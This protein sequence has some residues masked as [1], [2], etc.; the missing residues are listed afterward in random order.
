MAAN[1]SSQVIPNQETLIGDL[2]DIDMSSG[3]TTSMP[4]AQPIPQSSSM[5]LLGEGLDSLLGGPSVAA[6]PAGTAAAAAP[7]AGAPAAQEGGNALADLLGG[8]G[9]SGGANMTGGATVLPKEVWLPAARGKGLEVTGTFLRRNCQVFM[10]LTVTNRA[11][12]PMSDFAVQFNKN[13][14]GLTIAAPLQIPPLNAGQ[15]HSTTLLLGVGG[16]VA[17]M[18]PLMNLQ[19]GDCEISKA[20]CARCFSQ[21]YLK[22]L[23]ISNTPRACKRRIFFLANSR[24]LETDWWLCG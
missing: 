12:Q 19:V 23:Y 16:A 4:T 8:L 6:A 22:F 7:A 21:S 2:L 18:E 3:P 17:K 20:F 11:M 5:D 1:F 13:S 9:M 10:D 15:S 24:S 14:F